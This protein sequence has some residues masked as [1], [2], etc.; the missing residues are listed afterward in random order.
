MNGTVSGTGVILHDDLDISWAAWYMSTAILEERCAVQSWKEAFQVW[1]TINGYTIY[2]TA[3]VDHGRLSVSTFTQS[4]MFRMTSGG[5]DVVGSV[6]GVDWDTQTL[7][8]EGS[9]FQFISI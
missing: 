3:S 5:T 4:N 9:M 1:G 7:L 8:L 6:A 2:V